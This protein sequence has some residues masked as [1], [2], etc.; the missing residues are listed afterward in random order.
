M[1]HDECQFVR[2]RSFE[3]KDCNATSFFLVRSLPQL[4]TP[5]QLSEI[6]LAKTKL[7]SILT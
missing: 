4:V 3:N 2:Q 5:W 6:F 7:Q 1:Q